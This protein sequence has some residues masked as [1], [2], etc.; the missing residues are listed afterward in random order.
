MSA[1]EYT[2]EALQD[3]PNM[4]VIQ[5]TAAE[6]PEAILEANVVIPF[7]IP[8]TDELLNRA[9]ELCMIMQ[10]GIGLE[11]VDIPA[12]TSRGIYVCNIPDSQSCGN[13]QS[14]AEQALYLAFSVLRN[15]SQLDHSLRN[16]IIGYPTGRTLYKSTAL[17][18]GYGGIGQQL[19]KRLS[20]FDARVY[21]VTRTLPDLGQSLPC[22]DYLDVLERT[23]MYKTLARD[24]DIV[25]ICCS[26][27]ASNIGLVDKEFIAALKPGA[28]IINVARGELFNYPDVLDA[29]R[30]GHLSGVGIDVYHTEPFPVPA[31]EF[32]SHPGVICTPHV[33]GVT[34]ISYR[35]MAKLTAENVRRIVA[36]VEPAGAVN[37]SHLQRPESV[38]R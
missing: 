15:Q 19:S 21:A 30:S 28:V 38:F 20:A 36:G 29:L 10:F 26:Q 34:H 11:C 9:K 23:D 35:N 31:D 22:Q 17:I 37:A 5:A 27:N 8:M 6:M 1:F 13:A 18:Y 12:A 3:V 7:M 32:M 33:A 24:A 4:E 14:C 2:R 25:F 16:G